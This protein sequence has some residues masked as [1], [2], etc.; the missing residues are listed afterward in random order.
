[1]ASKPAAVRRD[2]LKKKKAPEVVAALQD[3][4]RTAAQSAE[5]KGS[6]AAA[7]ALDELMV[8]AD[9]AAADLKTEENKAQEYRAAKKV[10]RR[11]L[12]RARGKLVAYEALIDSLADGDAT[13]IARA[14]LP[15]RDRKAPNPALAQVTAVRAWPG[16][17]PCDGV[18]SWPRAAG[19]T[20][21]AIEVNLAPDN[22]A[23]TFTEVASGT[24]RRRV[25]KGPSPGAKI[26]ARVA[27]VASDGTR[28]AWSD[29][30]LVTTRA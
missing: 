23:S 22:P 10:R 11:S 19:A 3:V 25:L 17:N 21:Y 7:G 5:V 15:S 9:T 2:L 18:I 6:I 28:S 16:P 24:G 14:G 1:M 8:A 12:T 27:A 4:C 13:V 29:P 26:L 30:V 20:S